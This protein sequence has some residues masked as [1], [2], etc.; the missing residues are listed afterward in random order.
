MKTIVIIP[1]RMD[2]RRLFGKPL[3]IVKGQTIISHCFVSAYNS[4]LMEKA[5]VASPDPKIL[6]E[7][8]KGDGNPIETS[9]SSINGTERVAEAARILQ[10]APDDIVVNLQ[11][12]MPFFDPEIIDEPIMR[13]KGIPECNVASVM[14]LLKKEDRNN[15][16]K[17][18]VTVD[19]QGKAISFSREWIGNSFLHIGVYVFRN[20]FL[21]KYNK[22]G[23]VAEEKSQ[24]LEQLR[25]M[26]MNE[27]IWMAFVSSRP[28]V[29]D[30]GED[31][32]DAKK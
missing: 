8:C 12:D 27:P 22:Y 29:I 28:I 26:H 14:T 17:V 31:L 2:S 7:I 23:L 5:Y 18:K 11:G 16:N 24:S 32:I 15:P 9:D 21:Q 13:L 4:D 1:A 30:T 10:L 20:S 25:T 6:W 19:S 3:K